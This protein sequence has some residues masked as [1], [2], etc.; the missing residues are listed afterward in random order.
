MSIEVFRLPVLPF[1]SHIH[2]FILYITYV[3]STPIYRAHRLAALFS[4]PSHGPVDQGFTV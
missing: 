1:L 3:K 2:G 4:F